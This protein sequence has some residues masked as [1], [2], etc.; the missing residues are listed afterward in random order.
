MNASETSKLIIIYDINKTT[1]TSETGNAKPKNSLFLRFSFFKFIKIFAYL[2][3]IIILST[4][5]IKILII[6]SSKIIP[7]AIKYFFNEPV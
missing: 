4:E 5:G 7:D 6:T 1:M 3:K 2:N